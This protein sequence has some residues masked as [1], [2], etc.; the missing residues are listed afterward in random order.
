MLINRKRK[1]QH[2]LLREMGIPGPPVHWL[3]GNLADFRT[4]VYL[5]IM[6]F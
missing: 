3:F 6:L 1:S 5:Q 2:D 4:K